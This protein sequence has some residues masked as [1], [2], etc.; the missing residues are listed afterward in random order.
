MKYKSRTN[1][2]YNKDIMKN[3][4]TTFNLK[5]KNIHILLDDITT[6]KLSRNSDEIKRSNSYQNNNDFIHKYSTKTYNNQNNAIYIRKNFPFKKIKKEKDKTVKSIPISFKKVESNKNTDTSP[7]SFLTT[8]EGFYSTNLT[9]LI[10]ER[11]NYNKILYLDHTNCKD[12]R[13]KI[14]D[15]L[16]NNKVYIRKINNS[17]SKCNLRKNNNKHSNT[18][19]IFRTKA[20]NNKRNKNKFI[21]KSKTLNLKYGLEAKIQEPRIV[22]KKIK[23]DFNHD[24]TKE[25][26]NALNGINSLSNNSIFWK[27]VIL[28]QKVFRNFIKKKKFNDKYQILSIKI[29]NYKN[30]HCIHFVSKLCYKNNIGDIILIQKYFKKFLSKI[31]SYNFFNIYTKKPEI[32]PCFITKENNRK[33]SLINSKSISFKKKKI[34]TLSKKKKNNLK[35]KS[36]IKNYNLF[37]YNYTTKSYNLK[38]EENSFQ[39]INNSEIHEYNNN[40][41]INKLTNEI[42]NQNEIINNKKNKIRGLFVR[43]ILQK[44]NSIIFQSGYNY[45]SLL[46]FINSIYL[47]FIK[48]KLNLFFEH[49]SYFNT[50][51]EIF[52]KSIFRHINIYKRNN[53]NKNEIIHLIENNLPEGIKLENFDS[54]FPKFT[55]E[56][57]NNLINTQILKEDNNLVNYIYLFFKYEKNKKVNFKFIENRLIKEPLNYR[58]IFTVLRYIDN[59][60]AKIN[61][62]KICT[63]CFCKK[64]ESVCSLNC[65]CHFLVNIIYMNSLDFKKKKIKRDL[66]TY[67]YV[68]ENIENNP[69]IL[70]IEPKININLIKSNVEKNIKNELKNNFIRDMH[71]NDTFHYFNK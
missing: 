19:I 59:L 39:N 53:F 49:L 30:Y 14:D 18:P 57:E 71:I 33:V 42:I 65:N 20:I 48:Y 55:S 62:N 40:E 12:I 1:P 21:L 5:I 47:I 44:V 63:N 64:N 35:F 58:N 28:I 2:F 34:S 41:I 68:E 27:N 45:K 32:K 15:L 3:T 26:K 25:T 67:Q 22:N 52:I 24:K 54:K 66:K 10:S 43:N 11:N 61:T 70:N 50:K 60:D 17:K 7:P 51:K 46:N 8:M 13:C 37:S 4:I 56:Q 31:H 9:G 36:L 29:P 23:F 16:D 69:N 38:S 6:N